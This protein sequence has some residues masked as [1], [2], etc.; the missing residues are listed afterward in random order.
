MMAQVSDRA[1]GD[2]KIERED[3]AQRRGYA[4]TT[5][6]T[7]EHRYM[8]PSVTATATAATVR[9][10]FSPMA[11]RCAMNTATPPLA[12]VAEQGQCGGDLPS[13]AQHVRRAGIARS[14]AARIGHREHAAH[15]QCERNRADQICQHGKRY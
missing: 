2:V 9:S 4:F 5:A 7:Q 10:A 6:K 1:G 3:Y 11:W 8:W 15:D 14:V 13:G 12:G